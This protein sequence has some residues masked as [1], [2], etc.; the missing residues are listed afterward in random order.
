MLAGNLAADGSGFL[1][2]NS[3]L[4]V[5]PDDGSLVATAGPGGAEALC[6]QFRVPFARR[7]VS[8]EG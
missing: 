4:F 1:P 7:G 2:V 6:L 3:C 5:G 8:A